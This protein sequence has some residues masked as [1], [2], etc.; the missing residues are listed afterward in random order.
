MNTLWWI[1]IITAIAGIGG[2]GLGGLI[3]LFMKRDSSRIVSLLLSFAGGIMTGVV[4][5]DMISG[6]LNPDGA[7]GP[8][9][10]FIVVAGVMVGYLVI[11]LRVL[12]PRFPQLGHWGKEP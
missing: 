6:A 12:Y 2:T 7:D 3:S 4:C 9:N 11:W 8:V 1:V 10:V 5:F